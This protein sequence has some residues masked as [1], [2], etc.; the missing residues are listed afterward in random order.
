[1][2]SKRPQR[3]S[4]DGTREK[5]L[6]AATQLFM[7]QG[8]AGT[9]MGKLAEKA[10][11]NQTLIF[12][13]FGNKQKLWSTV[14]ST[15]VADIKATP[16]HATPENLQQ[17]LREVISQ[18]LSI[19]ASRPELRK[20]IGWQKLENTKSKQA[21]MDIPNHELS[22][23]R[24]QIPLTYLKNKKLLPKHLNTTHLIIWL[25]ASIDVLI[26]DDIGYFKQHPGEENTYQQ[27]LTETLLRGIC[28]TP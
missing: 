16:V 21:I 27:L 20:L 11:I 22:P 9:S 5:I 7:R 2:S 17:F 6:K 28:E 25:V 1:M 14:K 19:Y 13:H 10:G 3:P 15:M 23:T 24:W 26:D 4:A 18:R 8:Y 12:H